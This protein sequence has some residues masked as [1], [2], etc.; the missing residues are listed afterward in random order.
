VFYSYTGKYNTAVGASALRNNTH[1]YDN[2]ATGY[3]ALYFN[4]GGYRNTATG[5]LA[6]RSNTDGRWNTA[7]GYRALADGTGNLNTAVGY[8]AHRTGT[9]Y[10]NTTVGSLAFFRNTTGRH[11]TAIGASALISNEEGFR[12]TGIGVGAL[13][14]NTT[15]NDNTACGAYAL[16]SST[17][18]RNIGLGRDA[19]SRL[20]AGSDNIL[21]GTAFYSTSDTEFNTLRIGGGTGTENFQQD[22][23]FVSGIRNA[24]LA[25]DLQKV[26]VDPSDQLGPCDLSSARFKEQIWDLGSSSSPLL[27]LRPVLFKY[28]PELDPDAAREHFG[29]IAEEVAEVFPQLVTTDQ[30][31][32]PFTV[33]YDLLTPLLLNELQKQHRQNQVQ[34]GLMGVMFLSTVALTVSRWRFGQRRRNHTP[35]HP[36]EARGR[37]WRP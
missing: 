18:S 24:L 37:P 31:G 4:T 17:G 23:A 6:L 29:L 14:A 2:T 26:C 16:S 9:G 15:G 22:R 21:I 32:R 8:S 28:R 12:N 3:K 13:A 25:P 11:N 35:A 7:T 19:G 27:E 10:G 30:E 5:A 20:Q 33:R 34:W 1:G 36:C